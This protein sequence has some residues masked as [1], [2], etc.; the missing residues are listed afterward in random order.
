L[1]DE[2][3]DIGRLDWDAKRHRLHITDRFVI[4]NPERLNGKN[5]G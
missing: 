1:L 2:L 3:I 4:V 5:R